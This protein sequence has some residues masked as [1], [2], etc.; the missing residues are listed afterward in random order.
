MTIKTTLVEDCVGS[1]TSKNENIHAIEITASTLLGADKIFANSLTSQ[2]AQ[3]IGKTCDASIDAVEKTLKKPGKCHLV[4]ILDEI[5]FLMKSKTIDSTLGKMLSWASSQAHELTIIGISNAVGDDDARLLQS[6]AEVAKVL[7][8]EPYQQEDLTGIVRKRLG[9]NIDLFEAKAIEYACKRVA[10]NNGDARS[11]LDVLKRAVV[12][13]QEKLSEEQ[14]LETK[15]FAVVKMTHILGSFQKDGKKR[16]A[17]IIKSLP[18]RAKIVLCVATALDQAY[19]NKRSI[20]MTLL[21]DYTFK[22]VEHG[23][24]ENFSSDSFQNILELLEDSAL[25]KF[26]ESQL[27]HR[28]RYYD[29]EERW[30]SVGDQLD[31]INYVINESL[32]DNKF[33]KRIVDEVEKSYRNLLR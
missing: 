15:L 8:F 13:C 7:V 9:S 29:T 27:M 5:Q 18:S 1:V 33:Y 31:E 4:M 10:K 16:I 32:L 23:L 19:T 12:K 14:L 24:L 25:I 20:S 28:D 26:D 21:K 6:K 22:A 2:V 30:I 11:F 3:A 17:E